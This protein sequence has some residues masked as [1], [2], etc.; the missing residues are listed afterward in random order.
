MSFAVLNYV[1]GKF[2]VSKAY[3]NYKRKSTIGWSI[4]NILLDITGGVL[5]LSQNMID[6]LNCQPTN[7]SI[8]TGNVPKML[9][10]VT[11]ICM[12]IMFLVQHY[13]LYTD[14]E[15]LRPTAALDGEEEDSV[16]INKQ[17]LAE[18]HLEREN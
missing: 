1:T 2:W 7:W 3:L 15:Q 4:H 14:R 12:D 5:S 16:A 17:L 6:A 10:G 11:T 9:L 18:E 8:I 13:V